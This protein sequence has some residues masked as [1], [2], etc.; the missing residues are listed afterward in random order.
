[1][2]GFITYDITKPDC[3]W[4]SAN[5]VYA[6]FL[7]HVM[8]LFSDE[9]DVVRRLTSSKFNQSMS[10]SRLKEEDSALY[11]RILNAFKQ[12]CEQ[13]ANRDSL[14]S[15]NGNVL[16]EESQNQFREAIASLAELLSAKTVSA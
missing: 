1:M 7:D 13:I 16:D 8:E 15:V 5:W 11:S 9:A 10:L 14:A 6:S 4:S 2:A 3:T 12:V